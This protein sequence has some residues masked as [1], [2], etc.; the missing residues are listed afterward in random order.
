MKIDIKG[1]K[2]D[3]LSV[4]VNMTPVIYFLFGVSLTLVIALAILLKG[5]GGEIQHRYKDGDVESDSAIIIEP[6]PADLL[7]QDAEK[8]EVSQ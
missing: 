4:E 7:R 5:S 8:K 2:L 1:H 3:S 6:R